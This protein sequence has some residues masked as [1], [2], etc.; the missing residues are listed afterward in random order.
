MRMLAWIN[1]LSPGRDGHAVLHA[2]AIEQ[3]FISLGLLDE[4]GRLARRPAV[5][6]R[7]SRSSTA[8]CRS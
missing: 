7:S 3:L 5:D 1:L 6:R 4:R 8:T 2:S